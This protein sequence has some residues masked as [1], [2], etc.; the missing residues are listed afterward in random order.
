MKNLRYNLIAIC[1]WFFFFYNIEKLF[2]AINIATYVYVLVFVY[3]VLIVLL[4]PLQRMAL[5]WVFLLF[6]LPYF[7]LMVQSGRPFNL[8]ITV[9]EIS[10]I[11]IT[12]V[13]LKSMSD[14]LESIRE[15][16][17]DLTLGH[18]EKEAITF[19]TGQSRIYHEIRRARR[20][21][22]PASLVTLSATD[23]S[24]ETSLDSFIKEAQYEIIDN[25]VSARV[26]G[27]L[28]EELRDPNIILRRDD[29]FVV[30]LPEATREEAD[31]MIKQLNS[32]AQEN[33]GLEFQIGL[34][35]FPDEAVTFETLLQNAEAEMNSSASERAGETRL[36]TS[37][38]QIKRALS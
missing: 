24:I 9:T 2:G 19:E 13:L 17:A 21:Q 23:H 27:F 10:A 38:N 26:A 12:I 25:Y 20:F 22:R 11:L 33:L 6:L 15:S 29:H 34:S 4:R 8:P 37:T 3:S 18:L 7:A 5:Q 32:A 35:S 14:G 16:V 30:L 28:A 31:E 36:T 1:T